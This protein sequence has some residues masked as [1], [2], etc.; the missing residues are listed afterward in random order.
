MTAEITGAD[1]KK[2]TLQIG[3]VNSL[4]GQTTVTLPA[5][6]DQLKIGGKPVDLDRTQSK[7]QLDVSTSP[8]SGSDFLW[9]LGAQRRYQIDSI[10]PVAK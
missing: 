6:V 3:T 5:T 1:N 4:S 9:A 2:K 7:I 10:S 8:T